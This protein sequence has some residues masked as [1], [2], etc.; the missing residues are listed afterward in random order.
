MSSV[1]RMVYVLRRLFSRFSS[2]SIRL[3]AFATL[4]ASTEPNISPSR[5]VTSPVDSLLSMRKRRS[6]RVAMLTVTMMSA[7][8]RNTA[9]VISG[10]IWTMM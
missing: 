10:L 7:S 8:G 6:H 5:L 2:P 4:I 1:S 3:S 9:K